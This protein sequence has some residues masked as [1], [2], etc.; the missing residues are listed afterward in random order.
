MDESSAV[1]GHSIELYIALGAKLPEFC[2]CFLL[3]IEHDFPS[4][5]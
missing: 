2:N 1:G 4:Q 3:M 5:I